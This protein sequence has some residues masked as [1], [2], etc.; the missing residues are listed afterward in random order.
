MDDDGTVGLYFL[1]GIA[2]SIILGLFFSPYLDSIFNPTNYVDSTVVLFALMAIIAIILFYKGAYG[3]SLKKRTTLN[4]ITS[5]DQV[6]MVI[7]AVFTLWF[8]ILIGTVGAAFYS[9]LSSDDSIPIVQSNFQAPANSVSSNYPITSVNA[10]IT[11]D[12]SEYIAGETIYVGY[13]GSELFADNAWIGM[14]PAYYRHG[15]E[16]DAGKHDLTY[17][18][19]GKNTNGHL[20][21]TAP[22]QSGEYDFR[23][24]NTDTCCNG[25]EISSTGFMVTGGTNKNILRTNCGLTL[26]KES[27][28]P[29]E[30]VCIV[31]QGSTLHTN[32]WIGIVPSFVPHG[33]GKISDQYDLDYEYIGNKP[34]GELI[35]SAPSVRGEYEMRMFNNGKET[36]YCMFS[37][38]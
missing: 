10:D 12:K 21:F 2:I 25:R 5:F 6:I 4:P 16:D 13:Q 24:F 15:N 8:F 17:R 18:Y 9:G 3:L 29:G 30:R 20:T 28:N 27:Y 22:S 33:S 7:S 11:L 32:A 36:C 23:I 35:L 19:I 31:Y 14:F 26:D 34:E 38:I 1:S 37:V